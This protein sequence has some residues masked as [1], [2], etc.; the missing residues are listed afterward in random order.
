[1]ATVTEAVKESLV[2]F[3]KPQEMSVE[4]RTSWV[5]YAKKDDDGELYM[6]PESFVDAIAPLGQDYVSFT[7]RRRVIL[8]LRS[9]T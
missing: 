7:P 2:G 6:D 4:N 1:M 3:S 9:T 8:L 5:Q